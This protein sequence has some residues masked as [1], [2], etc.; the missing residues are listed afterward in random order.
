MTLLAVFVPGRPI[1]QG[2][3]RAVGKGVLIHDNAA[4]AGWRKAIAWS[5]RAALG[6]QAPFL[7]P[8]GVCC[9]FL[10]TPK[11]KGD[12]PDL[13]KLVRAVLDALTG[14]AYKD[15]KQVA[16]IEATRTLATS[17]QAIDDFAEQIEDACG[18]DAVPAETPEEG[19]LLCLTRA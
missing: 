2:S 3:M 17:V 11:R 14:I 19:L 1:P 16:V 13:D 18:D 15:D 4:L 8:V 6:T 5:V 10:V 12:Q 9:H 7:T